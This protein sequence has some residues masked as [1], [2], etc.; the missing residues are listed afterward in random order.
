MIVKTIELPEVG[1]ITLKKS[2]R[3]KR[4]ILRID[5]KGKPVVTIPRFVPYAVGERYARSHTDW[6]REHATPTSDIYEHGQPIGSRILLFRSDSSTNQIKTRVTRDYVYV[7]LPSGI[8]F[9]APDAQAAATKACE[10]AVKKQAELELLPLLSEVAEEYDYS[11]TTS[12]VK[13]MRSRWGSCS[14]DGVIVLNMWLVQLPLELQEYVICHELAHLRHQNHQA[15]FW[16]EVELMLPNY[17]QLRK[18]LKAEHPRIQL[19]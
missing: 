1:T 8:D 19:A 16:A 3:A 13:N 5:H 11:F 7:N 10:R 2:T 17:K 9:D 14:S 12:K 4:L 15:E 6:I 18:L